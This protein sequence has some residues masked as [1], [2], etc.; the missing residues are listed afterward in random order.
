MSEFKHLDGVYNLADFIK[1]FNVALLV[2][3]ADKPRTI[4]CDTSEV[5]WV[6]RGTSTRESVQTRTWESVWI[7]TANVDTMT[8]DAV[9]IDKETGRLVATFSVP[10]R[11]VIP[12]DQFHMTYTLR[13]NRR[14]VTSP[15]RKDAS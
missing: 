5:S 7:H 14:I 6:D 3:E 10:K 15:S 13:L 11:I 12:G 9:L 8:L 2:T 4:V 1:K